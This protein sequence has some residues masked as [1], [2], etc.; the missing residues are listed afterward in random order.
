M[1]RTG[2]RAFVSFVIIAVYFGITA[3]FASVS[4]D[5]LSLANKTFQAGYLNNAEVTSITY[6]YKYID[7]YGNEAISDKIILYDKTEP[8]YKTNGNDHDNFTVDKDQNLIFYVTVEGNNADNN[9]VICTEN[10]NRNNNGNYASNYAFMLEPLNNKGVKWSVKKDTVN[11]TSTKTIYYIEPDIDKSNNKYDDLPNYYDNL[12]N[13]YY[14]SA[15]YGDNTNKFNF[16]ISKYFYSRIVNSSLSTNRINAAN[17]ETTVTYNGRIRFLTKLHSW[18]WSGEQIIKNNLRISFNDNVFTVDDIDKYNDIINCGEHTYTLTIRFKNNITNEGN[19]YMA[20]PGE[21]NINVGLGGENKYYN[22]ATDV[23][24]NFTIGDYN[25]NVNDNNNESRKYVRINNNP[26]TYEYIKKYNSKQIQVCE[27]DEEHCDIIERPSGNDFT[28]LNSYLVSTE[29]LN[30]SIQTIKNEGFDFNEDNNAQMVYKHTAHGKTVYFFR[31]PYG[32]KD[33]ISYALT[34]NFWSRDIKT[35]SESKCEELKNKKSNNESL[36]DSDNE[37]LA[38]CEAPNKAKAKG[39]II[40]SDGYLVYPIETAIATRSYGTPESDVTLDDGVPAKLK[41]KVKVGNDDFARKIVDILNKNDGWCE[42]QSD[43]TRNCVEKYTVAKH[44]VDQDKDEYLPKSSN[45]FTRLIPSSRNGGDFDLEVYYREN[46]NDTMSSPTDAGSYKITFYSAHW[47]YVYTHTIDITIVNSKLYYYTFTNSSADNGA[48]NDLVTEHLKSKANTDY[49]KVGCSL[50]SNST[51]M[52]CTTSNLLNISGRI[53][54]D[55][56]LDEYINNHPL[57]QNNLYVTAFIDYR[58]NIF[59]KDTLDAQLKVLSMKGYPGNVDY[60]QSLGVYAIDENGQHI[61]RLSN[62]NVKAQIYTHNVGKNDDGTY[63]FYDTTRYKL[64]ITGYDPVI[65]ESTNKLDE[66]ASKISYKLYIYPTNS[67]VYEGNEP[68][69]KTLTIANFRNTMT[70]YGLDV[71][72]AFKGPSS[73]MSSDLIAHIN[74]EETTNRIYLTYGSGKEIVGYSPG[75]NYLST[76]GVEV[77]VPTFI[78]YAD[79]TTQQ[80]KTSSST[81]VNDDFFYLIKTAEINEEVVDMSYTKSGETANFQGQKPEDGAYIFERKT[82]VKSRVTVSELAEEDVSG[83]L[84]DITINP[85]CTAQN[86]NSYSNVGTTVVQGTDGKAYIRECT[87]DPNNTK[88]RICKTYPQGTPTADIASAAKVERYYEMLEYCSS[89]SHVISPKTNVP[90]GAYFIYVDYNSGDT[91]GYVTDSTKFTKKLYPELYDNNSH[92]TRLTYSD[93]IYVMTYGNVKYNSLVIPG[94]LA[95]AYE[96]IINQINVPITFNY[97]YDEELESHVKYEV[98]KQDANGNWVSSANNY[99]FKIDGVLYPTIKRVNTQSTITLSNMVTD[100]NGNTSLVELA[101]GNYRLGVTYGTYSGNNFSALSN[102]YYKEFTVKGRYYELKME[103]KLNFAYYHNIAEEIDAYNE[104]GL[105]ESAQ[106]DDIGVVLNTISIPNR[107]NIA[108]QIRNV[109]SD[110]QTFVSKK[111]SNKRDGHTLF[112]VTVGTNGP[113]AFRYYFTDERIIL[114]HVENVANVGEYEIKLSYEEDNNGGFITTDRQT[115]YILEDKH[116]VEIK[117]ATTNRLK[118]DFPEV[119][120]DETGMHLVYY[121]DCQYI[122][123]EEREN[124]HFEI[125]KFNMSTYMFDDVS[126]NINYH[127]NQKVEWIQYRTDSFK[128][129]IYQAKV[130]YTVNAN[131]ADLNYTEYYFRAYYGAKFDES[132][133]FLSSTDTYDEKRLDTINNM[134]KWQI[135][136]VTTTATEHNTGDTKKI[137]NTVTRNQGFVNTATYNSNIYLYN[138][139]YNQS[140]EVNLKSPRVDVV[141]WAIND[142]NES[143]VTYNG[144]NNSFTVSNKT[145]GTSADDKKLTLY[146]SNNLYHTVESADETIT[147]VAA[148]YG[149][150]SSVVSSYNGNISVTKKLTVGQVLRLSPTTSQAMTPGVYRLVIYYEDDN[151]DVVNFT[152]INNYANIILSSAILNGSAYDATNNRNMFINTTDTMDIDLELEG[153]DANSPYLAVYVTDPNNNTMVN[154][155]PIDEYFSGLSIN[156]QNKIHITKPANNGLPAGEYLLHIK[157][158]RAETSQILYTKELIFNLNVGTVYFSYSVG[159][160]VSSPDPLISGMNGLVYYPIT[161]NN[162][163]NLFTGNI[164][165]ASIFKENTRIYMSSNGNKIDYTAYFT[166]NAIKISDNQF[167]LVLTYNAGNIPNGLYYI[168]TAYTKDGLTKR[169]SAEKDNYFLVGAYSKAFSITDTVY[170]NLLSDEKLHNNLTWDVTYKYAGNNIYPLYMSANVYNAQGQDVSAYFDVT[171]GDGEIKLS[172]DK[173]PKIAKGTYT[174]RLTYYEHSNDVPYVKEMPLTIYG[175]YKEIV[176]SNLQKGQS[177]IYADKSNQ[178]YTFKVKTSVLTADEV[179]AL[180]AVIYDEAGNIYYSEIDSSI[181]KR[182][183]VTNTAST[184]GIYTINIVPFKARVGNYKVALYLPNEDYPDEFDES[185]FLDFTIDDTTYKVNIAESSSITPKVVYNDDATKAYDKDG[186]NGDITFTTTYNSMSADKVTIGV[187]DGLTLVKTITPTYTKSGSNYNVTFDSGEFAKAGNYDFAICINGLPYAWISKPIDKYIPITELTVTIGNRTYS[188]NAGI[189]SIPQTG[190]TNFAINYKPANATDISFKTSFSD[191]TKVSIMNNVLVPS[192]TG[193]T[194]LTVANSD[195]SKKFTLRVSSYLSSNVYEVD[196]DNLLILIRHVSSTTLSR[197]RFESNLENI[198]S[199]RTYI[200]ASTNASNNIATGDKLVN[201]GFTYTIVLFGDINRNGSIELGDVSRLYGNVIGT[202][203]LDSITKIG[204][205]INGN[206]MT[207]L[208]DVSRLYRYVI[209][210]SSGY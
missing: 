202:R 199:D 81:A 41:L 203:T 34:N 88:D 49:R 62:F 63:N 185:N 113:V 25:F 68:T 198:T 174:V 110:A 46:E 112:D 160:Y 140:I 103:E 35:V 132:H 13:S 133:D 146:Y 184:N 121:V 36:S 99:G 136:S 84:F 144:H 114:E 31:G 208:S 30:T 11:S 66:N 194:E 105:N 150:S 180:K 106:S 82:V 76:N 127:F 171:K 137:T 181:E 48:L 183:N 54:Y 58:T 43:P 78:K 193:E 109:N 156:L 135:N 20:Y 159:D 201:G 167:N 117:D 45:I 162:I 166:I 51:S 157:Y 7:E 102:T 107:D 52:Y 6:S 53:L 47:G 67:T 163:P 79:G 176:L 141:K 74:K 191:L 2:F 116:H 118:D 119:Y 14:I 210:N 98:Q 125:D 1:K 71:A 138:N 33:E 73:S 77:A 86:L 97:N 18:N 83:K 5:L 42:A 57:D 173:D 26:V 177:V 189:I 152:V 154:N 29:S 182:F 190:N 169:Y 115:F 93:P 89:E 186:V 50:K 32:T 143:N 130:T 205:D 3:F 151:Y 195:M 108:V 111:T 196:N 90:K 161:T 129:L 128:D 148:K 104:N 23:T 188:D 165:A 12:P 80:P 149:L 17:V 172:Y 8:L 168:E 59:L 197:S 27:E 126:G 204:T 19:K 44:Y 134:F 64:K 147:T 123:Y 100:S 22:L 92:M 15:N 61:D 69:E 155:R 72:N 39:A 207:D 40:A 158:S 200:K 170:G 75:N 4:F 85:V 187:Y 122:P 38:A 37:K 70:S 206:S 24:Q 120:A 139:L 87:A 124:I 96:N 94:D 101:S 16:N 9:R 56:E 164:T 60:S 209:G 178:Y 91:L 65:N 55:D 131:F 21:F 142:G 28:D 95:N 145:N 192:E 10:C 179:R 175:S 153:I